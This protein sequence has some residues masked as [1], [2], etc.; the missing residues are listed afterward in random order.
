M[1]VEEI[2]GRPFNKADHNRRLQRLLDGRTAG[3]IEFKHA[4]ISAILI[5][6]GYPYID[7][8][9]PRGNYQELLRDVV[10]GRLGLD[11]ALN[12]MAA[13][14]VAAPEAT[15]PLVID[16]ARVFVAA[17]RR[18]PERSLTYERAPHVTLPRPD[19]DYL[20]REA[21]NASLGA[22]GES[23]VLELE[24]ARLWS[25][26]KKELADKVEQVSRTKGDGLGYDI[27]SFETNGRE[28]L[29]EVKTTR[30][31]SM[32]PFFATRN[33]VRVSEAEGERYHLYRVFKFRDAPKVFLLTGSLR[34]ACNLDAV[35]YRA[36]IR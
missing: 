12:A 31:G 34:D 29:I 13:A 14:A 6:L 32:T 25:E 17:P 23:F 9:K 15:R 7:G 36:S 18:D 5:E 1:L 35:A 28:R 4:N 16:P 10:V 21:R 2:A 8:Y 24:H 26:G 27:L 20:E 19:I 30:Y 33:E 3:A 11:H 22:A